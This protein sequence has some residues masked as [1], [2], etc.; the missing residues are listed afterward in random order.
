MWKDAHR[1]ASCHWDYEKSYDESYETWDS[2]FG[3][4]CT[5]GLAANKLKTYIVIPLVSIPV[6]FIC[7][8]CIQYSFEYHFYEAWIKAINHP[9]QKFIYTMLNLMLYVFFT[10]IFSPENERENY[11]QY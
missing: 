7:E 6:Y 3:R 5:F 10:G 1:C 11:W 9:Y 2:Y 8:F 4:V